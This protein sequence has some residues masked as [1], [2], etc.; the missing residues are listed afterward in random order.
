MR[1]VKADVHDDAA[2]GRIDHVRGVEAAAEAGLQHD[3]LTALPLE[4]EHG[5]GR[6]Q[7]KFRRMLVHSFRLAADGFNAADEIVVSDLLAVDLHAFGKTVQIRGSIQ[8]GPISGG[9]QHGGKHRRTAALAVGP[10]DM[11]ES[12]LLLRVAE[13]FK[14]RADAAKRGLGAEPVRPVEISKSLFVFHHAITACAS[15]ASTTCEARIVEVTAP[16]P[17]GTALMQR[18]ICSAASWSTSPQSLRRCSS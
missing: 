12:Q 8:S 6:D 3:D 11:N 17:P 5:G 4:P 15:A 1:M 18:T 16:I 9:A 13:L 14:K 7:F 10:G 2:L